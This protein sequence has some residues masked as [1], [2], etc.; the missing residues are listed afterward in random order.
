[1]IVVQKSPLYRIRDNAL[2]SGRAV[3]SVQQL[4]NLTGRKRSIAMVYLSR[5]V[6]NKMAKRIKKGKIAFTDDDFII[7]TQL[8]EPSYISLDSALS[9]HGISK[10]VTRSIECVTTK[11]SLNYKEL[12]I[13]YHKISEGLFFG[14]ERHRRGNGY[15]FVAIPEKAIID[16]LYLNLYSKKDL[17]EYLQNMKDLDVARLKAL[18]RLFKGRG[19]KKLRKVILSSIKTN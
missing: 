5:L 8:V 16:G 3:F 19:S 12:G 1:M 10:Q 17:V 13:R 4:S 18:L 2:A 14:Y 11:N 7:A 6:K 9:Y 15:V